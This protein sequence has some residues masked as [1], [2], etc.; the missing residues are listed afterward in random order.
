MLNLSGIEES[1]LSTD[2]IVS[3]R[4][5]RIRKL[6]VSQVHGVSSRLTTYLFRILNWHFEI[7]RILRRPGNE[8]TIP[9]F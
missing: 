5:L 2:K 7:Y 3:Q 9:G 8:T 4:E 1:I 6:A